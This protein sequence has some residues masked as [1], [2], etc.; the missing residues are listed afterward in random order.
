MTNEVIR[1]GEVFHTAVADVYDFEQQGTHAFTF[2]NCASFMPFSLSFYDLFCV[3]KGSFSVPQEP[4]TVLPGDSFRT[5]CYYQDGTAWGMGSADE[6]CITFMMYYPVKKLS[7]GLEW[8]CNHGFDLGTGCMT[9]LEQADLNSVEDLGR[10]F[11]A[12]S[13][14]CVADAP[15][16]TSSTSKSRLCLWILF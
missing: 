13:G 15:S 10:S 5:T 1:N 14:E 12:T 11:G 8:Y 2:T 4:Y 7:M 9:E 6:M 16:T 3:F